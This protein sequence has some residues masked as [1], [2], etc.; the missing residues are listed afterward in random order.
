MVVGK[1][2]KL[3]MVKTKNETKPKSLNAFLEST[4]LSPILSFENALSLY[5]EAHQAK[6]AGV[7]LPLWHLK[8]LQNHMQTV[9]PEVI[10]VIGF[11]MGYETIAVKAK[12]IEE[13]STLGAKH[14]DVVINIA[15]L[16]SKDFA[17]LTEEFD[18]LTQTAHARDLQ[19]KWIIETAYLSASEISWLCSE[20]A[21]VGVDYVKTSTGFAPT[22]AE[23]NT[24]ETLRQLLPKEI[25]IKASGGIKTATQAYNFI[26]AGAARIGTSNALQIAKEAEELNITL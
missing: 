6:F 2:T 13:A 1:N 25:K 16:K 10:T 21:R 26:K 12:A 24:V 18:R 15:A 14:V 17:H 5:N 19:I 3:V 11:P 20:A 23:L 8:A 4:A 22:G 9:G 7:C